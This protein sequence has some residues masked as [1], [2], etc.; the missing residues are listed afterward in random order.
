VAVKTD[1]MDE[2]E[3]RQNAAEAEELA[4]KAKTLTARQRW[5]RI[6]QGW[7]AMLRKPTGAPRPISE[8]LNDPAG[9]VPPSSRTR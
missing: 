7:L 8:P 9:D 6:A 5:R 4:N 2:E 3:V 1:S